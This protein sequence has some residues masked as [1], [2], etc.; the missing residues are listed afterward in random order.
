MRK[1]SSYE[2]AAATF[3]EECESL[4]ATSD[5]SLVDIVPLEE[6]LEEFKQ[7]WNSLQLIMLEKQQDCR[8]QVTRRF[9]VV[10]VVVV[11][12]YIYFFQRLRSLEMKRPK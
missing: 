12:L 3:I 8:D 2:P 6:L 1:K 7:R 9:V 10:V 5:V 4:I 11:V